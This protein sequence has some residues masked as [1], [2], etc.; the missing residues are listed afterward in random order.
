MRGVGI[1]FFQKIYTPTS[2]T[3]EDGSNTDP[4]L[5]L[6]STETSTRNTLLLFLYKPAEFL[7]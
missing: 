3:A 2:D 7:W 6:T 5:S 1:K 4:K